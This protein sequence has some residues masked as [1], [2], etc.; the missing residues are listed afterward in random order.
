MQRTCSKNNV[1]LEWVAEYN[2]TA[3]VDDL[4]DA[5]LVD[6][7]VI[8]FE[9]SVSQAHAV[10]VGDTTQDLKGAAGDFISRHLAR[11]DN[12]E[13]V[14]GTV[15]HDFE[16]AA[17]FVN[18]VNG[19]NDV[20]VVQGGA[21]AE[22]SRDLF[23]VVP[24]A[25]VGMSGTE[26]L[27]SKRLAIGGSLHQSHRA[28]SSSSKHAAKLAI[29]VDKSVVVGERNSLRTAVVG[30]RRTSAISGRRMITFLLV[31]VADLEETLQVDLGGRLVLVLY[32]GI[33][34]TIVLLA[35]ET[36][37]LDRVG[38][39]DTRSGRGCV[40]RGAIGPSLG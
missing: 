23:V 2:G 19:L 16:P 35:E 38:L 37:P 22:L 26:L 11:H 31:F 15:L 17:L 1:I 4:H 36:M 5:V 25:L 30:G 27:D 18:D 6:N 24:L 14:K 7:N 13:Q 21:Y 20:S 3:K 9:I 40:D 12:G 33:V 29:F 10:Q 28:T 32:A 34:V 8:K 39:F